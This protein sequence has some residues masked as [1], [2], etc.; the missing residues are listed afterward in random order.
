MS[1]QTVK[2][3]RQQS[4]EKFLAWVKDNPCVIQPSHERSGRFWLA[5]L[6]R[7]TTGHET[8]VAGEAFADPESVLYFM[9]HDYGRSIEVAPG[10]KYVLLV[11]DP[12]DAIM[13]YAY[14]RICHL[15]QPR[16]GE[17]E[18]TFKDPSW[19]ED[20][21]QRWESYLT[22]YLPL[23]T[24]LVYYERLCLYPLAEIGRIL[25]FLEMREALPIMRVVRHFDSLK[26]DALE[27]PRYERTVHGTADYGT[28]MERYDAHC[29]EWQRDAM[30]TED[31]RKWFWERLGETM[32][33]HGYSSDG[34]TRNLL[35]P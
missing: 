15:R 35:T 7:G 5:R 2:E 13:S 25:D 14:F 10:A 1:I 19:R 3:T 33:H 6:L 27:E 34:H 28:G 29:L 21:A 8:R 30:F 4:Y 12:R 20:R 23:D 17:I 31:D 26:Y 18:R 24:L 22:N 11:R 16:E 9:C 32:I